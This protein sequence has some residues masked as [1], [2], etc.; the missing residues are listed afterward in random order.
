MPPR[1]RF[2]GM[3]NLVVMKTSRKL[4]CAPVGDRYLLHIKI[5]SYF[6]ETLLDDST[7]FFLAN[8]IFKLS[9]PSQI[10]YH[11]N[12]QEHLFHPRSQQRFLSFKLSSFFR[13][14]NS[15]L[16]LSLPLSLCMA[17]MKRIMANCV[18][19]A[20]TSLLQGQKVFLI[21]FYP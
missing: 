8:F 12:V 11:Q 4:Q 15:F 7:C 6:N 16:F 21:C 20:L 1:A 2:Q 13:L 19:L 3:A 14:Y 10:T 9:K 18:T 5:K 17:K